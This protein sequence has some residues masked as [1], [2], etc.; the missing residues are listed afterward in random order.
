MNTTM[1]HTNTKIQQRRDGE[2]AAGIAP[3]RVSS[4]SKRGVQQQQQD[5]DRGQGGKSAR[6]SPPVAE[7]RGDGS[8]GSANGKD[9]SNTAR[10]EGLTSVRAR[11][12][13]ETNTANYDGSVLAHNLTP[14]KFL[15]GSARASTSTGEV[16]VHRICLTH[17][18]QD[19][20]YS[21]SN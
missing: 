5:D 18:K 21:S 20:C 13:K 10:E 7:E 1:L 12:W 2:A 4:R 3:C 17:V 6:V 15:W 14:C 16:Y 9:A 11:S 19:A 8:S